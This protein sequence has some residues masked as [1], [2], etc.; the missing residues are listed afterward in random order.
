[1]KVSE[2][3]KILETA[4]DNADIEVYDGDGNEWNIYVTHYFVGKKL[5][6]INLY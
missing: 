1:M 2:L 4:D 3:K 6:R 5:F